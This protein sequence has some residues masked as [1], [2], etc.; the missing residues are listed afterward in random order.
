M[1]VIFFLLSRITEQ[2]YDL[3]LPVDLTLMDRPRPGA[4]MAGFDVQKE[5][6]HG[7]HQDEDCVY[8]I[9][10]HHIIPYVAVKKIFW[11]CCKKRNRIGRVPKSLSILTAFDR[12]RRQ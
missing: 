8:E 2:I 10:R 7:F 12:K 5:V 9:A 4:S 3:V 11:T 1:S 6:R